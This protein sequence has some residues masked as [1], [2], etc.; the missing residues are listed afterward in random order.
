MKAR[1]LEACTPQELDAFYNSTLFRDYISSTYDYLPLNIEYKKEYCG[2]E[3]DYKNTSVIIFEGDEPIVSLISYSIGTLFSFFN[4]PVTIISSVFENRDK[5]A[6]A[7]SLLFSTLKEIAKKNNYTSI[8]F[9]NNTHLL[10][11]FF[12]KLTQTDLRF[13]AYLD[14]TESKEIIKSSVRKS[15]KSLINWSEKNMIT[16]VV[17]HDNPSYEKF[18]SFR[19]F[20]R[21]VSGRITRSDK[22]WELQYESLL[23]NQAYLMLGYYNNKLASGTL[24]THGKKT[25]YYCV[26]VYDRELMAADV[27]LAHNNLLQTMYHAK[28]IGLKEFNLGNLPLNNTDAKEA[29][30]FYFKTGFTKFMRTHTIFTATF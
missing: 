10:S 22:T 25:A 21:H 26:G 12:S 8:L 19:D 20:H 23:N 29:N 15:Y 27:G 17:S 4:E 7:L 24:V 2:G 6:R 16:E 11:T 14:L 3:G 30:I 1:L 13:E 5:E 9:S 28:D 18:M